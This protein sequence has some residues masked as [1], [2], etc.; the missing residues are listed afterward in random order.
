[1]HQLC[2]VRH[3]LAYL[4]ITGIKKGFL[5]P[6]NEKGHISYDKFQC[7][8]QN[9]C[10]MLV[11]RRG[12]FGTHTNRKTA[13]LFA[14]W[15]GGCDSEIMLAAR[16][17][18]VSNAIKYKKDAQY[19]LHLAVSNDVNFGSI[20]SK[21][22][23]IFV[24]D[25]QMGRKVNTRGRHNFTD[26]HTIATRFVRKI[27]KF[28]GRGVLETVKAIMEFQKPLSSMDEIIALCKDH[29]PNEI[30]TLLVSKIQ[31]YTVESR[32]NPDDGQNSSATPA[33]DT[34]SKQSESTTDATVHDSDTVLQLPIETTNTIV[35]TAH[36][37]KTLKTLKRKIS[38]E[39]R[40]GGRFTR[41]LR[42]QTIP[43]LRQNS[44]TSSVENQGSN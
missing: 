31:R 40:G 17:K 44:W 9:V 24:A 14:V 6:G 8:F 16:H 43:W 3:L 26:L 22:R 1:M 30:L 23:S 19:L 21:W 11:E 25:V 37:Q 2:P 12:P 33:V 4:H 38:P 34:S 39:A 20:V 32:I 5:F 35:E 41:S 29:L 10:E 42:N 18:T 13:Y 28:D 7:D 36:S 27:C 15:G